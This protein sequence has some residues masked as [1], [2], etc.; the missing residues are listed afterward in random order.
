M[1]EYLLTV[2]GEPYVADIE[3]KLGE[4]FKNDRYTVTEV[5]GDE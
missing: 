1:S 4:V 2:D 3:A 5:S